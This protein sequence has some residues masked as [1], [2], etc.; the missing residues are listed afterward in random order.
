VDVA[1]EPIWDLTDA[2]GEGRAA[3]AI[4][5]LGRLLRAGA[6]E[7]VLLGSLAS[8]FRKLARTRAGERLPAPPFV[9]RK[10]ESQARRYS[11][12]RLLA[13]LDAIHQTDEALKGQGGLPSELA[14][15]RL[16]LGLSAG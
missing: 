13:H 8:H 16:V 11:G 2:I 10:L 7:P 3:D 14:L 12:A 5:L 4:A 1:E 6:A 15:E 9:Q